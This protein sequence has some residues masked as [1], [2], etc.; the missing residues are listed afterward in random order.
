MQHAGGAFVDAGIATLFALFLSPECV[1][2]ALVGAGAAADSS[3]AGDEPSD[4]D[5]LSVSVSLSGEPRGSPS[6]TPA[7]LPSRI[8][9]RCP[10]ARFGDCSSASFVSTALQLVEDRRMR[11]IEGLAIKDG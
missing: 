1:E 7:A 9:R 4:S 3:T 2:A 11:T 6:R 10:A 5:S 8:V